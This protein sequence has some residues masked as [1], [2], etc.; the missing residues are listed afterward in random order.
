MAGPCGCKAARC[1]SCPVLNVSLMQVSQHSHPWLVLMAPSV[2]GHTA[3]AA[4]Q[5]VFWA[6]TGFLEYSDQM[7]SIP[8]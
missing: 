4:F 5:P 1:T 6:A 8:N 7:R 3:A 2:A